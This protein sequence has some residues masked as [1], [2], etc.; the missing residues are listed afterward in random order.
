MRG[1]NG[2]LR[3]KLRDESVQSNYLICDVKQVPAA[4]EGIRVESVFW[5]SFES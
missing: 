3:K 4:S 1:E 5:V 2:G